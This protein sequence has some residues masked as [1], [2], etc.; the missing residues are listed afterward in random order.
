MKGS[1][2]CIRHLVEAGSDLYLKEEQGKTARDMAEELKG[3]VPYS[4]ALE[5]AGYSV[6][7]MKVINRLSDVGPL[8]SGEGVQLTQ[9]SGILE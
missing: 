5:E 3:L 1:K 7:G 9:N 4:R 2:P 6:D 8:C